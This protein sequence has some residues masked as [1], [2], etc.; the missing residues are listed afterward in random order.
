M[1]KLRCDGD[2][3]ERVII[4]SPQ[5]SLVECFRWTQEPFCVANGPI[6]SHDKNPNNF[7]AASKLVSVRI[8]IKTLCVYALERDGLY[9]LHKGIEDIQDVT[10]LNSRA[11]KGLPNSLYQNEGKLALSYLFISEHTGKKPLWGARQGLEAR[12]GPLP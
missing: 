11:Y 4:I 7:L 9:I 1:F 10:F 8:W 3:V 5:P 6:C 2:L 12:Y